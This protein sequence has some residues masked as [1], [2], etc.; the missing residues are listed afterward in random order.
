MFCC[1]MLY[2]SK[3]GVRVL[4]EIEIREE[5][6]R[7]HGLPRM[8]T[9]NQK[10]FLALARAGLWE[11]DVELR[12]FWPTDFDE[13][14]RLAEEQNVVGLVTAGLEHVQDVKVP[15]EVLLQFIGQTLQLEQQNKAMNEFIVK[16]IDRM[17][18]A[19]IYALL[20][21]GQGI[22]QCYEKPLWRV[23]GDVDLLLSDSNY[24]KAKEFLLPLASV[25]KLDERYSKHLGMNIDQWYVEI[26]GTLR[27]GLSARIDREVDAV[28]R[29]AFY[30]GNVRS[31]NNHGVLIFMPAPNEDVFFV[32]TDFIMHFY[33]EGM[34]IRQICDWCRLLW[35][36]RDKINVNL[37]E[38]RLK[39][40]RLLGEWKAFATLAVD[41][42]GMPVEAM[43]FYGVRSKKD[44][45]RGKKLV[46]FIQSGYTGSVVRDTWQ[47]AKIFPWKAI[48]YSPS[49]FLN[50]NWLKIKERLC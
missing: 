41:Y 16:L 27:T 48:L 17:R 11:K 38:T 3:L 34:N 13:I 44:E 4:Y 30:G 2:I 49:I 46:E 47:I 14:M 8:N 39:R 25:H 45:V 42:L 23:S 9:N 22:A 43:P 31:W 12:E 32:F 50:V 19:D 1:C 36:Y 37:L 40:A 7:E 28:Q 5:S 24:K 18:G 21:K 10:T 35:K 33:K 15:Q 29:D 26:H 6:V 20:V